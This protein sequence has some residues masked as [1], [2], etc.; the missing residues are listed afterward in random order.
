MSHIRRVTIVSL[1]RGILGEGFVA[2]E[3]KLGLERLAAMGLQVKFAPG[4][5]LGISY[6]QEHP[7]V[8]AADLLCALQDPETDLI[9][10]AIGGDDTY[11]LLP[12]LFDDGQLEQAVRAGRD[13]LF[14]GFSDTTFNHFM[15]RK[16]G[17]KR[18]FY[19]QAFLP[20][21]CELGPDMLPYTRS[22]FEELI[23]TG[24]IAGVTPAPVWYDGR[25]DFSPA[26]VG[27][28]MPA[29]P[30]G[31]FELLQG[32]GD[33]SGEILGG[34]IDSM[35]DFFN[36]ERYPDTVEMVQKYGLFPSEEEWRGKILLLETSE[37]KPTPEHY[38]RQLEALGKTGVFRAVSGILMGKPMDETYFAE[39]KKLL[40]RAVGDPRLPILANVNVGHATP[41]CILPFGVPARVIGGREIRFD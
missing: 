23:S 17:M 31:G 41:R 21:L 11:R 6:L 1:S 24:R 27:A 4:A 8:R 10:C 18:T 2:H 26:A 37:E 30:N 38:A 39:Y 19:G 36:N 28:G 3:V 35:Y 40:V 15:L 12:Y 29:H 32:S 13:K 25:E 9:L 14:L 22:Y 34:C 7:E 20:D 5:R 33:F 16:A